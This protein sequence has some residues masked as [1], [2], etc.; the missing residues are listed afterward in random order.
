[1]SRFSIRYLFVATAWIGVSLAL[2]QIPVIIPSNEVVSFEDLTPSQNPLATFPFRAFASLSVVSV[3]TH[4]LAKCLAMTGLVKWAFGV[5]APTF[6]IAS[7]LY[8]FEILFGSY[9]G[10]RWF[11][12][13]VQIGIVLNLFGFAMVNAIFSLP[14]SATNRTTAE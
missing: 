14:F 9:P 12:D 6:A 3:P 7:W 13:N 5:L 8:L 1:M 2:L 10:A 4:I 11:W